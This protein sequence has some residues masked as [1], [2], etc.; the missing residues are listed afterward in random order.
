M[1][2]ELRLERFSRL[3]SILSQLSPHSC[4]TVHDLAAEYEVDERTIHRD[5]E[6]LESAQIGVFVDE[7]HTI[8]IG[9]NGYKKIQSWMVA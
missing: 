1:K 6:V 7:D 8:K 5:I 2:Y 9:R 4:V 3:F